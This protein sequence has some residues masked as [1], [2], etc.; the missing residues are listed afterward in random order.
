MRECFSRVELVRETNAFNFFIYILHVSCVLEQ[1]WSTIHKQILIPQMHRK[2]FLL[3]AFSTT[4]NQYNKVVLPEAGIN[5]RLFPSSKTHQIQGQFKVRGWTTT[6]LILLESTLHIQQWPKQ[7]KWPKLRKKAMERRT[8]N[9]I[10]GKCF[11]AKKAIIQHQP[12]K[13]PNRKL[14]TP[15]IF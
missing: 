4:N 8:K 3:L 2:N 12:Q 5:L 7:P 1:F 13:N 6:W 9:K 11:D 15:K 14:A 10:F